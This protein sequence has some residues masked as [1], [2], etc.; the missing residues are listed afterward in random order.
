MTT[1]RAFLPGGIAVSNSNFKSP[2]CKLGIG[3]LRGVVDIVHAAGC[4]ANHVALS[5]AARKTP[6]FRG[7]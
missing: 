5:G 7:N 6:I 2:A 1:S 3:I 4:L